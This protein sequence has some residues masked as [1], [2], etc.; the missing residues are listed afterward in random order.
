MKSIKILTLPE[1]KE[2]GR[3]SIVNK[4]LKFEIEDKGLEQKI[5]SLT[6][7]PIKHLKDEELAYAEKT[8]MAVSE[9]GTEEH[10]TLL[11]F[12]LRKLG[13]EGRLITQED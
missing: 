3:I 10:L 2:I 8:V 13:L 1:E 4:N 12:E 11:L 9:P 6:D 5:K 7:K